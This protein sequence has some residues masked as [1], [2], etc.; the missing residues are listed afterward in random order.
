MRYRALKP[1][2]H[3]PLT[4]QN[5]RSQHLLPARDACLTNWMLRPALRGYQAGRL[6]DQPSSPNLL[7]VAVR[8]QGL[9]ASARHVSSVAAPRA[10]CGSAP[11]SARAIASARDAQVCGVA[12]LAL[13]VGLIGHHENLRR[14]ED[15][16]SRAA[17]L[18]CSAL[19]PR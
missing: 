16:R 5:H 15:A 10:R 7:P 9:C 1:S 3:E 18:R 19:P 11:G 6:E 4:T 8:D 13:L 12:D 14:V 2:P 17:G